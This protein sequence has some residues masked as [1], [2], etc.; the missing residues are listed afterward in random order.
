LATEKTKKRLHTC[1]ESNF[2]VLSWQKG[3]VKRSVANDLFTEEAV[4]DLAFAVGSQR[5][6]QLT[7]VFQCNYS[8]YSIRDSPRP[9]SRL[10]P[11][12]AKA[13]SVAFDARFLVGCVLQLL[14]A[15]DE[16]ERL[17]QKALLALSGKLAKVQKI[18]TTRAQ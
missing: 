17:R 4:F 9:L 3:N 13:A 16:K 1:K 8:L 6:T 11:V 12:P 5:K 10:T 18:C 14:C 7:A 2:F 15:E